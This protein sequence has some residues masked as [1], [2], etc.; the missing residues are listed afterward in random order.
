M[1]RLDTSVWRPGMAFRRREETYGGEHFGVRDGAADIVRVEAEIE[2]N[3]L[4]KSLHA[5]VGRR[6]EDS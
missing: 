3:A 1:S 5:P 4:S 6:A 2:L